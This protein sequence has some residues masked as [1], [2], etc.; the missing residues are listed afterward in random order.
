MKERFKMTDQARDKS[1]SYADNV[2]L[3]IENC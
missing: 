3:K 2:Y 1:Y